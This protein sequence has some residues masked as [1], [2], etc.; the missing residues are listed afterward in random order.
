MGHWTS[1]LEELPMYRRFAAAF[2]I[3]AS[4]TLAGAPR[5]LAG[6]EGAGA[7]NVV[8]LRNTESG[9]ILT[10]ARVSVAH[11]PGPPVANENEAFAYASCTDCRTVAAA[12]QVVLVEGP[13]NDF[14]PVNAAVAVNEN[15]VR[16]ATFAYARQVVL[17]PRTH[18]EIGDEAEEQIQY[19]QGRIRSVT[20]SSEAFPQMSADLDSLTNQLVAVVQGEI[21]RAGTTAER[22]D[23]RK[24]DQHDD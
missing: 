18:V 12:I 4:L 2:G 10:R 7:N 22:S 15:C 6:D 11:D 24:V 13:T 8:S 3:V 20:R 23:D 9:E 1:L 16:C 17:S 19:L 5:A 21:Q 14:Q